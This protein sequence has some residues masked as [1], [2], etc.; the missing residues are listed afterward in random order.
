[1]EDT[2]KLI[3]DINALVAELQ[4]AALTDDRSRTDEFNARM[5]RL[6][7]RVKPLIE[8]AKRRGLKLPDNVAKK[9]GTRRSAEI[10]Q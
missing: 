5:D 4:N 1:M 6:S 3:S 10:R 7:E 9:H 2:Y 8:E